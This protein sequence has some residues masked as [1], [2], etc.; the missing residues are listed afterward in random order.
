[1]EF[2]NPQ[3][4]CERLIRII[5]EKGITD[6][7]VLDAFRKVPR[8]LFVDGA[9]YVQAYDDNALPIGSG[10]TISQPFVVALMT[11]LLNLQKDE[12]VLEIGTGSG[13]QTAILAQFSRRIYTIE[14]V[15]DLCVTAR[16]RLREMGYQNIVFKHGDGSEGWSQQAPFAKILVAA[17]APVTPEPLCEQLDVGGRLIIPVGDRFEQELIIYDKTEKGLEKHSKGSVVFV[18]LTGKYGWNKKE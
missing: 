16:R 1:M 9:M 4:A 7:R 8:H 17:A 6:E 11:Q 15:N 2:L 5:R 18:P 3:V 10:Q 14:S 12:K 13:F